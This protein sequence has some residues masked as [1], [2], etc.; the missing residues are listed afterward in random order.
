VGAGS[1]PEGVSGAGAGGKAARPRPGYI[2]Y[3]LRLWLVRGEGKPTWRA[4]LQAPGTR[5]AVG[6]EGLR[7]LLRFLRQAMEEQER[8]WK[9]KTGRKGCE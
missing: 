3:L 8:D 1:V 4:S 7:E 6:F 2:S 9:G 5:E